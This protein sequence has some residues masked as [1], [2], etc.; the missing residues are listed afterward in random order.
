MGDYVF[1]RRGKPTK[2][3]GVYP[4][5]LKEKYKI[6][7]SDK[8][9]TICA[10]DHLWSYYTT[11]GNLVSKTTEE[12]L[13]SGLKNSNGFK[14]KIPTNKP[15]QYSTKKY[16]IDPYLIGVFLGDGCCKEKYLTIS[17][18]TE[19]IPKLVG[20]II[21]ATPI[22]NSKRNYSWNFKW[23]NRTKTIRWV[24]GNGA[25]RSAERKK[26][27]TLDYFKKYEKYLI[28]YAQEKDIP[29]E[30]KYGDIE[31]RL[32]LIQGLM[33]TDGAINSADN[34]R[35]NMRFTSTSLKLVKS[36]QEILFSLGYSSTIHLDRREKK[37]TTNICYNLTI[38]VP[39]EEK[40][41]FFRLKRKR[42]I[43]L[44]AKNYKKRKDYSKISIV[45]IIP[46]EEKAEMV[47]IYVDNSEHLYLTNDYIVTHN[48]TLVKFIIEALG[49]DQSKVAY[50]AFCGKAAEVLRQKGNP[51]ACTLHHLLYEFYPQKNGGFYRKPKDDLPFN[52]IVVDEI[53]MA[54]KE[55]IDLLLSHS[56]VYA[57]F[58]GDP[59]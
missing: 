38:N 12:M 20:K 10:G 55:L 58:C 17:S 18:E 36:L 5:G 30:Y 21:N 39:N 13:S 4:Q 6:I 11:S 54:P 51:N 33:D 31:Q 59:F 34:H 29:P 46:L 24:G 23:N 16:T 19:E 14:Y 45:D 9:E 35:Y 41:K 44:E 2:V 32:S 42:D 7:L 28:Q 15:I 49:I 48:T 25:K 50:A 37:Y 27:K 56:G 26:P 3:L 8:R 1:D 52:V 43:A 40:Y 53:S 47:C 57:I 22:R